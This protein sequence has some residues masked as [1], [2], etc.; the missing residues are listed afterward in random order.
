MFYLLSFVNIGNKSIVNHV[1]FLSSSFLLRNLQVRIS[2]PNE[3]SSVSLH[4]TWPTLCGIYQVRTIWHTE[5]HR[6]HNM[7]RSL[8]LLHP[9]NGLERLD[10]ALPE[11]A[12]WRPPAASKWRHIYITIASGRLF[13]LHLSSM[14]TLFAIEFEEE[15]WHNVVRSSCLFMF[16]R[17]NK[18]NMDTLLEQYNLHAWSTRNR[19]PTSYQEHK[20]NIQTGTAC[21]PAWLSKHT[22]VTSHW[23]RTQSRVQRAYASLSRAGGWSN[24]GFVFGRIQWWA[25]L[26]VSPRS[27]I[28]QHLPHSMLVTITWTVWFAHVNSF[29]DLVLSS[30]PMWIL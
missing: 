18:I 2:L 22:V 24:W 14:V 3:Y 19:H 15:K 11:M 25:V 6:L 23:A 13:D 16:G 27:Q 30:D 17:V 5:L 12:E 26:I 1:I 4:S 10:V 28:Y 8:G 21:L 29:N 9:K 20:I 7:H